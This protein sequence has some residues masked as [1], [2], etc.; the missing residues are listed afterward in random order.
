[1]ILEKM[2]IYGVDNVGQSFTTL[3]RTDSATN[4]TYTVGQSEIKSDFDNCY[5]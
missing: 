4:L 5:P 3:T 2:K 1:M